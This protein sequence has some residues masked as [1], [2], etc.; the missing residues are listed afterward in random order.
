MMCEDPNPRSQAADAVFERTDS[1]DLTND[2]LTVQITDGVVKKL[3]RKG[4]AANLV[5]ERGG[6]GRVC[7]TYHS[8][9]ITAIPYEELT[10]YKD[11]LCEYDKADDCVFADSKNSIRTSYSLA[12]N[13]LVIQSETD[14][15]DISEFGLQLDFNFLSKKGTYFF[16]Q[17]LPSTLFSSDDKEYTYC[18]LMSPRGECIVVVAQTP[19]D[20]WKLDY[21]PFCFGHFIM[22]MKFLASF[23]RQFS[24]SNRKKISVL[25]QCTDTLDEAFDNVCDVYG[26]PMLTNVLSGGFCGRGIVSLRGDADS[27]LITSPSGKRETI[28]A[29]SV[30]HMKEYGIHTVIPVKN[31]KNGLGTTLYN[32]IDIKKVYTD[33]C[34]AIDRARI[35]RHEWGC[36]GV[37]YLWAMLSYMNLYGCDRYRH[38]ADQIL[39]IMMGK[40]TPN[41]SFSVVPYATETHAPYHIYHSDRIQAQFFAISVLLEAYRCYRDDEYLEF[42]AN[43]LDEA[44]DHNFDKGK[45]I[46]HGIYHDADYTTGC[47]PVIAIVDMAEAMKEK[48]DPRYVR[49]QEAAIQVAEHLYARG[50]DFPTEGDPV[51]DFLDREYEDGS[52]SCTAL[53]LLYVYIHLHPEARYLTFAGELLKMHN[54]WTIHTPDARQYQSSF[55][56][57]ETLWEGDGLGPAICAG[58]A[59]TIWRAEALYYYGV[60]CKDRK[61]LL[62][63]Y[64]GFITNFAKVQEDG[65]TFSCFETDFIKGGGCDSD[66]A[67]NFRQDDMTPRFRLGHSYPEHVDRSLA[68]YV[69]IRAAST[70]L[71][72]DI[73]IWTCATQVDAE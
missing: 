73:D 66:R 67:E 35:Y 27:F 72:T 60:A 68:L 39:P 9:D 58:H 7:Y 61:A 37:A 29:A 25:I 56:F 19:C 20:G 26:M 6:F 18:I 54:A 28:P 11:R 38:V 14:N 34:D 63:S 22:G 5:D 41:E 62:D 2:Y 47:A 36:E 48:N 31:G 65:R 52:I 69:W 55:R 49:Y 53:S 4:C 12:G 8:D 23:D 46:A 15:N 44:L 40:T 43:T 21:S 33:C 57:W 17:Y 59:W 3:Y 71:R 30:I 13:S 45:I 50:Y 1:M 51:P 24:P 16:D 70:W 32:G 10:A 64:N 42:A